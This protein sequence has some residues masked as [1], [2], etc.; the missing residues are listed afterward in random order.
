VLRR[1]RRQRRQ[2]LPSQLQYK[3]Q[4]TE[5]QQQLCKDVDAEQRPPS[6]PSQQQQR[7][8]HRAGCYAA[9][10]AAAG[11]GGSGWGSGPAA[12][13]LANI[14]RCV[15]VGGW[16]GRGRQFEVF[17]VQRMR[18]TSMLMVV[19]HRAGQTSAGG[20]TA[21]LCSSC[22]PVVLRMGP[23]SCGCTCVSTCAEKSDY[24]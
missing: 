16:G 3:P 11:S 12:D 6:P 15:C 5:Q 20:G 23:W 22:T 18:A 21:K 13:R 10:A 4:D 7:V 9:A 17:K 24:A 8:G 2:Q 14:C 1:R 19:L